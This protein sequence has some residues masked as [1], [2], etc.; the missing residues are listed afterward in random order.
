METLT[1]IYTR[2]LAD[3]SIWIF[4]TPSETAKSFLLYVQELGFFKARAK[5]YTHQENISSYLIML[6]TAGCGEY[7]DPKS[8]FPLTAGRLVFAD[9]MEEH[10]HY[11][12][13]GAKEPWEI[14]WVQFSGYAARGYYVQY[15]TRNL[16]YLD[17]SSNPKISALL[18][19][20]VTINKSKSVGVE[21]L[22]SRLLVNLLTEI[23]FAAGA[24]TSPQVHAPAYIQ[25]ALQDIDAHFADD[26]NLEYFSNKLKI[27]KFHFTREFKKYTG[28]SPAGYIINTRVNSAKQLLQ[29]SDLPV[30]E[31]AGTVGF[32]NACHFIN[33]FKQKTGMTPLRFKKKYGQTSR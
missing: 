22:T 17:V 20:L 30:A 3:D 32:H 5:Y 13:R 12:A 11:T 19:K 28:F 10:M 8:S 18:K 25:A 15:K 7:R 16:P 9:S 1:K 2:D 6:T 14:L 23:L 31:I 27:S 26:L 29:Y 33:T 4:N 21:F 24:V